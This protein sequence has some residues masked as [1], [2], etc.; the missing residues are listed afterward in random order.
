MPSTAAGQF[1]SR[2]AR[3]RGITLKASRFKGRGHEMALWHGK[4]EV[5]HTR[6]GQADIRLTRAGVRAM[7]DELRQDARIDLRGPGFDWILVRLRVT[8]DVERALE[9]LRAAVRADT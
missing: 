4:H 1:M 2:G 9:I 6:N 7:R 3:L 5:A 8:A